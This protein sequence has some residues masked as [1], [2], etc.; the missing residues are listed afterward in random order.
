V[1][2]TC[3]AAPRAEVIDRVVA[4]VG[5]RT[6]TLSD[7]RAAVALGLVPAGGGDEAGQAVLRALTDRVL[8]ALEV[9]RFGGTAPDEATVTRRVDDLTTRLGPDVMAGVMVR[10]GLDQPRLRAL[11]REDLA[12]E[13]YIGERFGGAVQPTEDEV[14]E[15]YV[16]HPE[17]FTRGGAPIPFAEAEPAARQALVDQRKGQ[18]VEGWLEGL[19]RRTPVTI[20]AAADLR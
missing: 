11:V 14:R 2:V 20:K 3:T 15:Y 10:T 1:V 12:I 18:F 5:S 13:S 7:V 9:E 19:R 4:T 6:V 17:A 8:M 16:G